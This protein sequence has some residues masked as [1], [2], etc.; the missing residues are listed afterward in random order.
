M[1]CKGE[2][3]PA[4]SI[5][6]DLYR[7][8]RGV[9]K[10]EVKAKALYP[11]S[12]DAVIYQAFYQLALMYDSQIK[13]QGRWELSVELNSQA[14]EHEFYD[15][16]SRLALMYF[17]GRGVSRQKNKALEYAERACKNQNRA[18]CNLAKMIRRS[19]GL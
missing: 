14:C 1:A 7:L 5:I 4:C 6:A 9:E 2:L 11:S 16:C 15:G 19:D 10:D 13:W 3:I 18:G 12:C 8:G 17:Q